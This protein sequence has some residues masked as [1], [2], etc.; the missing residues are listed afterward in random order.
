MTA[1]RVSRRTALATALAVLSLPAALAGCGGGRAP[2]SYEPL[3]F[4]YLPPLRLNVATID[5]QN[6]WK[7][8]SGLE[9]GF[10]APTPP[11]EALRRMAEDRLIAAGTSGRATFVIDKASIVQDRENYVGSFSVHLDVSTSDGTRSGYA[12]A[13]VMRTRNI[14]DDS[15]EGARAEL[16]DMVRQMMG[17]MNVEFEFQ[18]R[19]A[20]K[21]YLQPSEPTAPPPG[22]VEQQQ[23]GPPPGTT[24]SAPSAPAAPPAAAPTVV[25]PRVPSAVPFSS[26]APTP[27][28]H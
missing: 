17:D 24:E 5:I 8:T 14:D 12:S 1:N 11:S 15:L 20:L 19:H 26:P 22:P 25:A 21:D 4:D 7:P 13:S 27:L 28:T 18:V 2:V 6:A 3:S 10:L 9:K 23:L 16:Y